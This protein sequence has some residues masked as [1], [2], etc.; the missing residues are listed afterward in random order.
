MF[1]IDMHVHSYYSYDDG[2]NSPEEIIKSAEDVGLD[3]LAITDHDNL[4]GAI[5]AS[6]IET[7]LLIIKGCEISSRDGHILAYG[8]SELIPKGL[9]ASETIDMI[10]A[11]DGLA[12]ASHPY[13]SRRSGVGDLIHSLPFDAI[14]AL[15]GHYINDKGRT[16]RI[17]EE[18]SYPMVAGTDAHM[19]KEVGSCYTLFESIDDYKAE[20]KSGRTRVGGKKVSTLTLCENWIRSN[21]L[22]Q[23]IQ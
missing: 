15:N 10:H 18:K 5:K 3:G 1:K 11:Q 22:R 23:G 6:K 7:D 20:I 4:E 12:V 21:I 9:G 8:I 2:I 16:R 17:C 14:E 13:D 19:A